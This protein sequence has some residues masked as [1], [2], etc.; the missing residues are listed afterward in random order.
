MR[1]TGNVWAAAAVLVMFAVSG[2]GCQPPVHPVPIDQVSVPRGF[3]FCMTQDVTVKVTV[4]DADGNILPGF[5]VTVGNTEQEPVS[6]NILARGITNDRG[7]FERVV[8][9]PARYNTLR[10]QAGLSD[11]ARQADVSITNSE[12]AVSFGPEA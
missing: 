9:V 4:A 6:D 12:V 11:A 3:D 2:S 5:L 8:R 10:V 7:L 1:R